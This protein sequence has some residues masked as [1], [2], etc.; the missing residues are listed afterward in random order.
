MQ[1]VDTLKTVYKKAFTMIELIFVIVILGILAAVALPK[2]ATSQESAIEANAKQQIQAIRAS[3]E[4]DHMLKV[5]ETGGMENS[6]NGT[7]TLYYNYQPWLGE[8]YTDGNSSVIMEDID[9][10][11]LRSVGDIIKVQLCVRDSNISRDGG[12]SICKEKT[13]F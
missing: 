1:K 3:I 8:R 2:F 5:Q 11:R 10:F 4:S 7:L 9:T 6:G 12:Y 13:V